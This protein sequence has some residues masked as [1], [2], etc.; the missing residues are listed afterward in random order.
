MNK[1]GQSTEQA[2][3]YVS[4]R[5]DAYSLQVA[6]SMLMKDNLAKHLLASVG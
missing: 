1:V 5:S 4:D 3:I 6:L 2:A